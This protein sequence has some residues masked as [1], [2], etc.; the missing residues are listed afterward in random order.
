MNHFVDGLG[1]HL[2]ITATILI[3]QPALSRDFDA[4]RQASSYKMYQPDFSYFEA[5]TELYNE[6]QELGLR[7]V[8]EGFQ[9]S[10]F[11][12]RVAILEEVLKK[13]PKFIDGYWMLA[14]NVTR[15]GESFDS[16]KPE[17]LSEAR[18]LLVK[19]RKNAET[20][21]RLKPDF[22]MCKFFLGA[23]I[24]KIATI[25]GIFASLGTGELVLNS[26]IDVYESNMN[27]VFQDG[28]QLQGIVRYALGIFYRVVPDFF[29]LKW[30]FG[31]SGDIDKSIVMHEEALEYGNR[32]PCAKLMLSVSMYCKT[33]GDPGESYTKKASNIVDEILA[34]QTTSEDTRICLKDAARIRNEP[35]KACGYTKAKQQ[36]TD[37][38]AIKKQLN[39]QS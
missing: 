33:G 38:D 12:R 1:K 10:F 37:E 27:Y 13:N 36:E 16:S 32:G 11:L 5:Q 15:I 9:R 28:Y 31:I 24:G 34:S 39:K 3:S 22:P 25:D 19:A 29:L 2:L 4:G 6:Y 21:L 7:A 30:M 35:A 14:N 26:W 23:S 18:A 8:E 20:C 17:Q